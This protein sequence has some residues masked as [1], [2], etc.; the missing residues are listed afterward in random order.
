MN[1]DQALAKAVAALAMPPARLR[2]ALRAVADRQ[3]SAT[4]G[5][6]P[7]PT[8]D[9]P[10]EDASAPHDAA[11]SSG[12]SLRTSRGLLTRTIHMLK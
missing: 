10:T 2:A 3:A 9:R 5:D 12:C 6:P 11:H 8:A 4:D 7:P 1:P